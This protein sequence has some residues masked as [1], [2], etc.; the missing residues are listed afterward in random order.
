MQGEVAVALQ[1]S[2]LPPSFLSSSPAKN[3]AG[4][5]WPSSN[6]RIHSQHCREGRLRS[7][8]RSRC[9]KA[10]GQHSWG[11]EYLRDA[12]QCAQLVGFVP[13]LAK[14]LPDVAF[15]FLGNE[16]VSCLVCG[17]SPT[18]RSHLIPR[19]MAV[20]VQVGKA[21]ALVS[22]S[23]PG[24]RESQS[25]RF[26]D[27]ILCG[28]CD[29]S[30]G[31]FEE[32]TAKTFRALR[33]A[34]VGV[35]DGATV[36]APQA[37]DI[38]LRFYAALLWKYAVTRRD[39][40]KIDL[41]PFKSQLQGVAFEAASIPGFFDVALMRL[42]LNSADA[43]VFAYR[44]PKVDRKHGV[45]MYRIMVG[46]FLAFIK[47]DQRPWGD[48]ILARLAIRDASITRA[49]VLAAGEFEEFRIAQNLAHSDNRLS[50]F[51][52]KQGALRH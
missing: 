5:A 17:C 12:V 6:K 33:A 10:A 45:N 18:I 16:K 49:L 52:D 51:L 11:K 13:A 24:Y 1:A 28:P 26:D 39:F 30:L 46:G 47:V 48:P 15:R 19:V 41:G 20:E 2:P 27:R 37:P 25:G 32:S 43:D 31:P 8:R 7:P 4:W 29:S 42:R 44:A 50:A 3:R 35:S 36:S 22:T 40:G 21:H 14:A 34:A 23:S 9:Q 38:T